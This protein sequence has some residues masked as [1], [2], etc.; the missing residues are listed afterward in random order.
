MQQLRLHA[1][2]PTAHSRLLAQQ[3]CRLALLTGRDDSLVE[4]CI[5]DG[6]TLLYLDEQWCYLPVPEPVVHL[7]VTENTSVVEAGATDST[8]ELGFRHDNIVLGLGESGCVYYAR[9]VVPPVGH[10]WSA[11]ARRLPGQYGPI[12][13]CVVLFLDDLTFLYEDGTVEVF[14]ES[15]P[16]MLR[17]TARP[18]P[19]FF[20]GWCRHPVTE[21]PEPL[22]LFARTDDDTVRALGVSGTLY[23]NLC[24]MGMPGEVILRGS[25]RPPFS[26]TALRASDEGGWLL[27][28]NMGRWQR[29]GDRAT[30]DIPYSLTNARHAPPGSDIVYHLRDGVTWYTL[31]RWPDGR[32]GMKGRMV[33]ILDDR[34]YC[35]DYRVI[36]YALVE[37]LSWGA[38]VLVRTAGDRLYRLRLRNGD[39]RAVVLGVVEIPTD[40]GVVVALE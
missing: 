31:Y 3:R 2:A 25:W 28:N 33:E 29:T 19:E 5:V 13:D 21:L 38:C 1:P 39:W 16:V 8:G 35:T 26:P 4:A 18:A 30:R 22:A 10:S 17:A 27:R 32:L 14:S 37:P 20:A 6:A 23:D 7:V 34:H 9:L 11:T 40:V 36:D 12:R 24:Y 15:P